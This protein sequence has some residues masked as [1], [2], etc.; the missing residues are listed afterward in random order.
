VGSVAAYQGSFSRG[1]SQS[2]VAQEAVG[3][4]RGI[5]CCMAPEPPPGWYHD[6][7]APRRRRWWDGQQW[8]VR[9][10]KDP[11]RW[12][13]VMLWLGIACAAWLGASLL[14][15]LTA[16]GV[17]QTSQPNQAAWVVFIDALPAVPIAG[18]LLGWLVT[19]GVTRCLRLA[20]LTASATLLCLSIGL[21]LFVVPKAP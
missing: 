6:P 5:L 14:C 1:W 9:T 4:W 21:G 7:V 16:S 18:S 3:V 17:A 13:L 10:G 12:S 15:L 19:I 11:R 20:T 2:P 8:T